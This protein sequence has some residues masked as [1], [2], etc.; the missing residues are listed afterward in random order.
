MRV[1]VHRFLAAWCYR[2]VSRIRPPSLQR[3]RHA[4]RWLSTCHRS[5]DVPSA[6]VLT[7]LHFG[8]TLRHFGLSLFRRFSGSRPKCKQLDALAAPSQELLPYGQGAAIRL[9]EIDI[10]CQSAAFLTPC[11]V[12]RVDIL[13]SMSE[14]TQILSA[15]E[16]GDPTASK[17]LLPLVY[18]ELRRLA[19]AKLAREKTG[20]TLQATALVHDAYLRLIGSNEEQKWNSRGHFFAAAAEAMRRILIEQARRKK[21][22]KAGG[23]FERI[24][25][26]ESELASPDRADDILVLD[27]A[28]A[29]FEELHPRQAQVVKL[30]YFGGL[31]I[32][33]TAKALEIAQST[34]I[35]DWAYAK[36][37]LKLEI[38]KN[39]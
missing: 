29:K 34:A 36:G 2:T 3:R 11:H 17:K 38:S 31:T 28:L 30:R 14:I 25:I 10:S 22:Q 23:G 5:D 32:E 26:P 21:S 39:L 15:I 33:Q 20:Q 13:I 37:W 4:I 24:A 27:E 8:E 35:A 6:I 1:W 12:R 7:G 19:A 18:Q 9:L 16:Q